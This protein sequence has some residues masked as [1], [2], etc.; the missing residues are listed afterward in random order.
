MKNFIKSFRLL[1]QRIISVISI[2]I[3]SL[4]TYLVTDEWYIMIALPLALVIVYLAIFSVDKLVYLCVF[5]VPISLPLERF[6]PT[7][8]FNVQL[9]TE[10][11]LVGILILVIFRVVYQNNFNKEVLRHPISIAIYFYIIWMFITSLTS[12]MPLVSFKFLLSKLWFLASFYFVA[13]Q[14]FDKK[15]RIRNYVW[16]FIPLLLF[17]I[18]YAV[19]N[20]AKVGLFNQ[21]AAHLSASPF[22]NDHTAYGCILAMVLPFSIGLALTPKYTP[23]FRLFCWGVVAVLSFATLLSYSRAAWLGIAVVMVI[24]VIVLLKIKFRTVLIVSAVLGTFFLLNREQIYVRLEQNRQD[25]SK[26]LAKHIQSISNIRTDESNLERLNRWACALRMFNERPVFGWG[27]GTYMFKY[28]P[29][30][31]SYQK[32]NISTNAGTMGNAHSDYLG[33]LAESGVLGSLSFIAIGIISLFTGFTI[34]KKSAGHFA[35]RV[36]ILS[37]T[38]GLITYYVHGGL[39]NFLDSDKASAL[40]WG[41]TA[42]IV[43]LDVYH[44]RKFSEE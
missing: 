36:L 26:D 25:S 17:V 8:G 23:A 22:F 13:T 28:A 14:M 33:P 1:D 3:I 16:A 2:V 24:F 29:F 41:Y 27:P 40:F 7:L 42:M 39:N 19:A 30:Q 10:P 44:V 6:L 21:Q 20:L 37:A 5:F 9:P 12:S 34:Y 35:T 11:I 18:G 38:L 4:V 32:T 31:A 43:A 15:S